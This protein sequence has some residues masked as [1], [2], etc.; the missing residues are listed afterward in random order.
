[1]SCDYRMTNVSST[2]DA[3]LTMVMGDDM[4]KVVAWY[5]ECT[6]PAFAG[7]SRAHVSMFAQLWPA[8]V[9]PP[10]HLSLVRHAARR[11]RVGLLPARRRPG[12]GDRRQVGVSGRWRA[13]GAPAGAG[14]AVASRAAPTRVTPAC[15]APGRSRGR[16][17]RGAPPLPPPPLRAPLLRRTP[18][19]C[20]RHIAFRFPPHPIH[21]VHTTSVA[22]CIA[23]LQR[24]P[25][26]VWWRGG[27]VGVPPRAARASRAEKKTFPLIPLL[28]ALCV[29]H[30][31]GSISCLPLASPALGPLAHPAGLFFRSCARL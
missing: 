25:D 24:T 9:A 12:R 29:R 21:L 16:G 28:R 18:Q 26:G 13:A 1:V 2:I 7:A 22:V 30:V 23:A 19:F 4:V 8:D 5:G 14:E 20:A 17:G 11:Q 10:P 6:W 3:A 27:R 31:S 15:R